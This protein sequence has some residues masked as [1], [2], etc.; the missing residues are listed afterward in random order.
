MAG[1]KVSSDG[2]DPAAPDT[3]RL[4]NIGI[5]PIQATECNLHK[6]NPPRNRNRLITIILNV[7]NT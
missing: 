4:T 2:V 6:S 3:G 7:K 5:L 1:P